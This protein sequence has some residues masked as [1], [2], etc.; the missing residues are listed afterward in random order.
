MLQLSSDLFMQCLKCKQIIHKP[1]RRLYVEKTQHRLDD[2]GVGT[3][4]VYTIEGTPHCPSCGAVLSYAITA[5]E[6]Q[7][8]VV[9]DITIKTDGVELLT[10][11]VFGATSNGSSI[12]DQRE[13]SLIDRVVH[14]SDIA[15]REAMRKKHPCSE[16]THDHS[17]GLQGESC[18]CISCLEEVHFHKDGGRKTYNCPN[19]VN[20]YACRYTNRFASEIGYALNTLPHLEER[21][22]FRILSIG[23]GP[24]PDLIAFEKYRDKKGISAQIQYK[25]FDMNQ[26]WWPIHNEISQY[27]NNANRILVDFH[28]E[29]A[30]K[31]FSGREL[32]DANVLVLQYVIS[33]F[34]NTKQFHR[35]DEFFESIADNIISKMMPNSVVII[36][37]INHYQLGRDKFEDLI[38]ILIR[39]GISGRYH[40]HYFNNNIS[41][42]H[43]RYGTPYPSVALLYPPDPRINSDYCRNNNACSGASLLIELGGQQS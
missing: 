28:Y 35:L 15:Y 3:V 4:S 26:Y 1:R 16:C 12:Q 34:H 27:C 5:L 23:C 13:S 11:P 42:E 20:C 18:D 37:D 31:F 7:E 29:D 9:D 8:N 38:R 6:F 32:A 19:L 2:N 36:H 10:K 39:K 33:H 30:M 24:A 43:Q 14:T 41:N 17:H 21:A 40:K 22:D 25:G